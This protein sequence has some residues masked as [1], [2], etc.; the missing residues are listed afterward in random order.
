MQNRLPTV[1]IPVFRERFDQIVGV[2]EL[3][4]VSIQTLALVAQ[5]LVWAAQVLVQATAVLLLLVAVQRL[6]NLVEERFCRIEE[7]G[8]FEVALKH[9][10]A[11][12]Q[13]DQMAEVLV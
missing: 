3:P 10:L 5:V 1:V 12:G 6:R 13:S 7:V 11:W 9:R 8:H 2:L 4:V